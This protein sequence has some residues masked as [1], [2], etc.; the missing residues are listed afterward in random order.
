MLPS[1]PPR[2]WLLKDPTPRRAYN[3]A[4]ELNLPAWV[5]QVLCHRGYADPA[6]AQGFLEPSLGQLPGPESMA[7]LES[8]LKVLVP[9]IQ[10]GQ[11]IGVAGDYDA[12]GVTATALMVDFLRQAGATVV[13]DLPQR[14]R[15]G[16]GFSPGAAQRLSQAGAQVA[17]TVDCGISDFEG[18]AAA[19]DLGLP[20]VVTDHHQVPDGPLVPAEAVINPHQACCRFAPH[21]AGV[22]VAFYVA[23]GLRA[24]LRQVGHFGQR[25]LPNLRNSLDLV[26][27]GTC[28]DVVPLLDHNRILV[29]EG[30]K[31]L[32]EGRRVGLKA[33][34]QVAGIKGDLDA[35]D[36]GFG[37]APRLNA[38]GR[39]QSPDM[40]LELLL[41]QDP[42]Q[43]AHLAAGLDR[44]NRQ[45]RGLEGEI[46]QEALDM[47]AGDP[48]QAQARCLV[49]AHPGWHRGV[50]GI[51]ASRLVERLGR[52]A[53]LLALEDGKAVGSGRSLPG[54]HMQRALAGLAHL[55]DHFG[56]HALA[57]GATLAAGNLPHLARGLHQ[58]AS[59]QLPSLEQGIGLEL[60]AEVGLKDLG[61]E[62]MP[63]L[64]RLA[65]FGPGNPE[66]VLACRGVEV[67]QASLVGDG[68]LRLEVRQ[69]GRRLKGIGFNLGARKPSPGSRVDLACTP[70][71]S[72]YGGRHLE[73]VLED[74]R[75]A[76]QL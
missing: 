6:L 54:F 13:W 4:S 56:G 28:A 22:G 32:N 71:I 36:L 8:A 76:S 10:T 60:E 9:A 73:L 19:R 14:L 29:N 44:L 24:G 26:A 43:A 7:G 30:L 61:P 18:V 2:S 17:V 5:A 46:F 64:E 47:V 59:Q 75:P 72:T 53:M 45:R 34:C 74:L 52:P 15:D 62:L 1:S 12:D 33:L 42:A 48:V 68:H 11:V 31:V 51:V 49:L 16:Y 39:L 57:A 40:A 63:V 38:A 23:A 37:L 55:L 20:V 21:L 69:N 66:P 58:A 50:L 70:R 41:C 27:V 3:L 35:R 65:P 67:G 25:P